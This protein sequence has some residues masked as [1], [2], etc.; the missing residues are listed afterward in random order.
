M[1]YDIDSINKRKKNIEIVQRILGVILIILIY[2]MILTFIS[3][4]NLDTGV[5]LFGY[6][7]CII[8]SSSMEPTIN[9]GD[10]VVIKECKEKDLQ[11]GDVI[12][13]RQNQEVITHRILKIEEN[14]QNAEK[15]YITK[16]DNNNIEDT[17]KITYSKIQGK[18]V[19]TIPYLGKAILV[20]DNKIIILII[21][22]IL[23]IL[24]FYRIQ[25]QEKIEN[26]REKKRIEERKRKN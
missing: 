1:K 3:S 14:P 8:T 16:G 17:E 23:L 26:R 2:N 9:Y 5:G 22:L 6:K 10:V 25:K 15:T 21:I 11:T 12:T 19:L 20:L 7:A 4:D 18:C 13:F 24:C